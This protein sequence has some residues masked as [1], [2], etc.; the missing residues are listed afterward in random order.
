MLEKAMR[1][2]GGTIGGIF[3]FDGDHS[4]TSAV[5]GVT[6]AFQEYNDNYPMDK[7]Q[8]G[9]VPARIIETRG[10]VQNPDLTAG[11]AYRAGYPYARALVDLGGIRAV[12]AVPL[13]KDGAAVG[14]VAI[15]RQEP[16]AFSDEQIA[17][18]E[19]F[20]AQAVI[21][22]ENARLLNE[23]REAL[24][25]QTATAEVLQVI[26]ARPGNL[27]PVFE[28]MLEKAIRLCGGDRG[29][30]WTIE[31]G[32]GRLAAARGLPAEFVA[33]LRERGESGTNSPLQRV[34][35]GE[36]LI[37]F[38]DTVEEFSRSGD[39]HAKGAVEAGVRSAIWVA[40][41]KEG[42]T[43]GAFAIGRS[44]IGTFSDKQIALL[45]NFAAQAVIA[46]ENARLLTE[47]RE[48]LEQQTA[49]AEVLQ[50]INGSPGNLVPVFDAILEKAHSLCGAPLGSLVLRDGD[51][52]RAVATRGYPQE[53]DTLARHG[54]PPT[55]SFRLLLSGEPF[56]HV[57]D[58]SEVTTAREDHPMRRA[59][60]EIAGVRTVLFVPLRKDETVLGY[61]SAQ[62]QEVRPFTDRQIALLQN[63][64][65]QAVT[66]M[67]SAR[68]LNEIRQR[69]E[70]LRI[71]FEN[72][73]DGVALFDADLRLAAWNQNFQQIIELPDSILPQRPA[74]TD[75][76]RL[77][78]ER[79]EF[80]AADVETELRRRIEDT[81]KELRLERVRPDGRV[82][83]VRRNAVPGGGFVL[84][85]SDITERKRS[86]EEVRAARDAAE[87][88]YR[89]LKAAQAGRLG[90]EERLSMPIP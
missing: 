50:V 84:I 27:T 78:A 38:P 47:T 53:Y 31:G 88:A 67:E 19:N 9:T 64:A 28:A 85:Y 11:E 8:P 10:P 70:E 57:L 48:A 13:L 59:A 25:Q 86:E 35:Q 40:I 65:A 32:R 54:F 16:G 24:E 75:Y 76:L 30:L 43:V 12:L 23:Q 46:M 22:M 6:A 51:Q 18:L 36:W 15:Y 5:R 2:C 74:Y 56:R 68:L 45:Q 72:M 17:L 87:A 55:P 41:V 1:L 90:G 33:L 89:D 80:G 61:I 79:G 7:I 69:Q 39:P 52:L 37:E 29:V 71:T 44:V 62:R 60:T 63:F 34:V 26:N 14:M 83:E 4:V 21:A 20:A 73:G 77:L 42:V 66:A 81:D 82:I 58:S 49:T 3:T